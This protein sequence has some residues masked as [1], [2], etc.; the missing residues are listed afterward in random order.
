M[1]THGWL[2]TPPRGIFRVALQWPQVKAV[3]SKNKNLT[4]CRQVTRQH[5]SGRHA[6]RATLRVTSKASGSSVRLPQAVPHSLTVAQMAASTPFSLARPEA[7]ADDDDRASL[8]NSGATAVSKVHQVSM[9]MEPA[10]KTP[11]SVCKTAARRGP[12][13]E[14]RICKGP[15]GASSSLQGDR[16]SINV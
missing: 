7:R 14:P 3:G 16:K 1:S 15:K 13:K 4:H 12:K 10:S 2:I 6:Q 5:R 11:P 8:A 9:E